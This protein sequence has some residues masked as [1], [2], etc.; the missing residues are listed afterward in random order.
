MIQETQSKLENTN[1][2]DKTLQCPQCRSFHKRNCLN[3]KEVIMSCESPIVS[4]ILLK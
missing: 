3:E 2:F 4:D 1:T